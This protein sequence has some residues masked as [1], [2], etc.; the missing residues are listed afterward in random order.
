MGRSFFDLKP[1]RFTPPC[2]DFLPCFA[3]WLV[4]VRFMRFAG[5]ESLRS[6]R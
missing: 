2:P 4:P 6:L 1:L 3:A 5:F